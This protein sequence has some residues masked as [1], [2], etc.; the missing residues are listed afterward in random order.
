MIHAF[1]PS[2]KVWFPEVSKVVEPVAAQLRCARKAHGRR[3]PLVGAA[4][5]GL[6]AL[7]CARRRIGRAIAQ[8]R[9]SRGT[10]NVIGVMNTIDCADHEDDSEDEEEEDEVEVEVYEP[11]EGFEAAEAPAAARAAALRAAMERKAAKE[12]RKRKPMPKRGIRIGSHVLTGKAAEIAQKAKLAFGGVPLTDYNRTAVRRWLNKELQASIRNVRTADLK[13]WLPVMVLYVFYKTDE[14]MA[15]E[16]A[17]EELT[18][19]GRIRGGAA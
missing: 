11:V 6:G 15:L 17:E 18:A 4:V 9:M 13:S 3:L 16:K 14:D 2:D 7:W 5:V 8:M 1:V 12:K 10:R 19:M